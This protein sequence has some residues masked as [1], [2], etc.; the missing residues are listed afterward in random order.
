M[1]ALK[2]IVSLVSL[3]AGL[4]V[5]YSS[6]YAFGANQLLIGMVRLAV[7]GLTLLGIVLI[8]KNQW[9]GSMASMAGV[10][11]MLGMISLLNR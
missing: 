7:I 8:W 9:T 2:V 11:L 3:L 6:A 4:L 1:I 5:L 10:V